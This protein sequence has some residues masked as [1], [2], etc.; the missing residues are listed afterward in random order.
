MNAAYKRSKRSLRARI[1]EQRVHLVHEAVARL[2]VNGP[3]VR[4]PLVRREDLL[5]D[6]VRRAPARRRARVRSAS[7]RGGLQAL[8]IASRIGEAVGMVDAQAVR[9]ALREELQHP[10][11][12]GGEDVV[13]LG[14]QSLQGR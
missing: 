11:M 12:R 7:P 2:A 6:D 5:D 4:Q 10:A 3:R 9:L 1:D 14:A 8:E 13:A